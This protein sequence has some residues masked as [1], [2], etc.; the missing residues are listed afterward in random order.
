[1]V[2]S[3][4]HPINQNDFAAFLV[5]AQ[6]SGA[7][8]LGLANAGGDLTNTIKQA[9]EFGVAQKMKEVGIIFGLNNAHA[10]G[11]QAS[12][13]LIAVNPFYWD[14]NDATRAWSRKFIERHSKHFMPNDMQA[15]VY[16]ALTHYFKAVDKLGDAAD[17]AAVVKAM[18]AMPTDD[19][20]FGKGEIRVDGRK[21]H[22]MYVQEAKAPA[23]SK[24]PW[25]YFKILGSVPADQA[26]RPLAD[27]HCPL[28]ASK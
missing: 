26:F 28:V 8:V 7:D 2:G 3:V 18:K 13:G 20:L 19:P 21:L 22:A 5:Q 16:A 25:D 24:Q 11:L 6:A 1:M 12:Q 4:R 23:D 17:G 10:L 14:M 9:A 27:G 15:G